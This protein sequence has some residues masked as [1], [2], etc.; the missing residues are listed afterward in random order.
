MTDLYHRASDRFERVIATAHASS[1]LD[2]LDPLDRLQ[3]LL[4][5]WEARQPFWSAAVLPVALGVGEECGELAD[6]KTHAEATDAVGDIAIY[7][8]Q[9]ATRERLA[10]SEIL[11]EAGRIADRALAAY[12]SRPWRKLLVR[13][14]RVN[15]LALKRHQRIRE[16]ALPDAEYRTLLA[17]ALAELLAAVEL[18]SGANV[19]EFFARTAPTVLG[20]AVSARQ[21]AAGDIMVF[22]EGV[23]AVDDVR[24]GEVYFRSFP[25]GYPAFVRMTLADFAA[26]NAEAKL[27]GYVEEVEP[28]RGA[29]AVTAAKVTP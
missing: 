3:I 17:D 11:A 15:H 8:C 24:D 5:F 9:V 6:A 14:G 21:P 18:A 23:I 13:V 29:E 12:A 26:S 10:M 28:G 20:W 4:S 19:A 1:L 16:G 27:I 22:P 25:N 7:V 2:H